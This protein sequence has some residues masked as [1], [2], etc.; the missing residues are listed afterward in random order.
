MTTLNS[1]LNN[2]FKSLKL[3]SPLFYSWDVGIRF[4]VGPSD[5]EVWKDFD[6]EVINN[7][8]FSIASE[9]AIKIFDH[10]FHNQD[11]IIFVYQRFS[12]GR[13][14]IN[15]RSYILQQINDLG[16]KHI[17]YSNIKDIYELDKK[18]YCF[19]RL[20]VDL[21]KDEINYQSILE[22]VINSDFRRR[23]SIHG[24]CFF[25]NKSKN[26]ILY[27]YDDRGM[28]II[29]KDKTSLESLYSKFNKWIID[30]DREK[31]DAVF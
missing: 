12:D 22:G 29:A 21:Y 30:Y 2:N 17:Y 15:K 20:A 10:I 28:D 31:I 7:K 14:K 3:Q 25:I 13:K 27:L 18:G 5:I 16:S 23:P 1:Y 19:K 9:K 4:E 26:I 8:Y 11:K 24:D 6:N